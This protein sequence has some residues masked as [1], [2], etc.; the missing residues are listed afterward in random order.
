MWPNSGLAQPG[1]GLVPAALGD[2]YASELQD[3]A[4]DIPLA[5]QMLDEAGYLDTDE[6]GIRECPAG[7]DCGGRQL[8][9]VMQIPS[10]IGA[11]PREAELLAGLVGADRDQDDP[12][13][14]RSAIR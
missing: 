9:I 14:A 5:N 11:G 1:L 7:M 6:D 10:D 12:P 2:F 13:G 3:Y 4:F 8:D